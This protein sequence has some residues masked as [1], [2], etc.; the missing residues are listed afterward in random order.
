MQLILRALK[1][2]L[3]LFVLCVA[4]PSHAQESPRDRLAYILK[5]RPDQYSINAPVSSATLF[6]IFAD[7]DVTSPWF[8]TEFCILE[9]AAK[10]VRLKVQEIRRHGLPQEIYERALPIDAIGAVT[11]GFFGL[12]KN[13][14]PIPLGLVK[15]EGKLKT[16]KHPWTSGGMIVSDSISIR[17]VPVR[18]FR[19]SS[20]VQ[21]ALQSKPILVEAGRDG[22]RTALDERFD[23]SAVALTSD[24]FLLFLV[25]HEPGGQAAS[26]AEFS[27]LLLALRSTQGGHIT[28]A[29]AM[30]GGPGAHLFI[31]SLQRHCGATTPN[32]FP[33]LLVLTK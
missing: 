33:N 22:I 27:H 16:P 19:D 32:Y 3:H 2:T 6:R 13:G 26:L 8:G 28:S 15:S 14:N 5:N 9:V 7:R 25:I 21:H 1:I 12:D 24:G 10:K 29:L 11:G 18:N 17:I 30:D 23:R 20:S 4:I 31:P